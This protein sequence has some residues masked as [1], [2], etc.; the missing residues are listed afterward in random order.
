MFSRI[1]LRPEDARY[2]RFLWKDPESERVKV[3]QMDRVT[4]GDTCSP[5]IAICTIMRTAHEFGQGRE[6]AVRAIQNNLY[7]DDYLDS[8][9]TTLEAIARARDVQ[10]ILR[11]GDFHLTKW[12]SNCKE[13]ME[14]LGGDSSLPTSAEEYHFG[15]DFFDAKVLGVRWGPHDDVLI[16]HI[17][18]G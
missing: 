15:K 2:H 6:E 3:F 17:D 13:L 10:D 14:A 18:L 11:K 7:M 5:F 9:R 1:R 12:I 4:F 16:F 8:A